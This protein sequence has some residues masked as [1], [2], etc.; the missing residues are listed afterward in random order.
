VRTRTL[1]AIGTAAAVV[2]ATGS[3]AALV[4]AERSPIA[5]AGGVGEIR[6]G[7]TLRSLR[8]RKLVGG[9]RP[10]CEL[11]RGERMAPLRPPLEGV[12]HFYPGKRVSAIGITAGAVT[13]TGVR[14][15][16]PVGKALRAYPGAIYDPPPARLPTLPGYLW[17]GGRFHS[18]MAMV[19][20]N[21][22]RQVLEIAIPYP[23][24]CE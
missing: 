2:A 10:G 8:D 24:I 5:D 15:G 20:G 19:I 13:S 6:I 17:I 11:A 14:I 4:S 9:V 1:I 16:S 18:R 12:A 22:S 21:H 23:S 7:S 3:A